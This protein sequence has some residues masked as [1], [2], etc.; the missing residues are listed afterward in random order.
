MYKDIAVKFVKYYFI[1]G[2]LVFLTSF[3]L[4][5]IGLTLGINSGL[6]PQ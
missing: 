6:S 1:A 5:L 2:I 3:T 4:T